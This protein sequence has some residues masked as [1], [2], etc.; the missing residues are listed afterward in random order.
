MPGVNPR[1]IPLRSIP[2][3]PQASRRSLF[4]ALLEA[5]RTH[6]GATP[7]LIDVDDRVLNYDTLVKGAFAL[8]HALKRGTRA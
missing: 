2:Y 3:S 4:Q 6:G 7:A 8:G 1:T 5:R